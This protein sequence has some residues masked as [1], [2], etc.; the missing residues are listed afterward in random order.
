MYVGFSSAE[1]YLQTA[2]FNL[3]FMQFSV[4]RG[5]KKRVNRSWGNRD[6][7]TMQIWRERNVTSSV[8]GSLFK[9][10]LCYR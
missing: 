2:L 7:V 8:C 3:S 5:E 10:Y 4:N 9:T 1:M 6:E